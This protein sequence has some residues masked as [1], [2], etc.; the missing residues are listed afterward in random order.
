MLYN[1]RADDGSRAVE[2]VMKAP[3]ALVAKARIAAGFG[4]KT[5]K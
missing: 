3:A 1:P 4:K 2:D 5:M